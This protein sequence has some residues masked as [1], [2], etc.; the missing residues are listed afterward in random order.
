MDAIPID[1]NE[2]SDEEDYCEDDCLLFY[3]NSSESSHSGR[4]DMDLDSLDT[5]DQAG[6]GRKKARLNALGIDDFQPFP[7]FHQVNTD[8]STADQMLLDEAAAQLRQQQQVETFSA[9]L[10]SV[11]IIYAR[12]ITTVGQI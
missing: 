2:F 6:Q 11:L 7:P 9:C 3:C 12:D 10:C 5:D 1:L 8:P 4:T